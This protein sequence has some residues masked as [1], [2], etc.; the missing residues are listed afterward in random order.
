MTAVRSDHEARPIIEP[1]IIDDDQR[2]LF[3]VNR[4]VFVDPAV[5][6][7]ERRHI[8]DTCWLYVGHESELASRGDFLTRTVG[9]REL[10]VVRGKDNNIRAFFN[11]CPHRGARTKGL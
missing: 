3:R 5:L 10:I 7:R 8:F 2:G 6:A 11:T 4:K 1:Y 9:G